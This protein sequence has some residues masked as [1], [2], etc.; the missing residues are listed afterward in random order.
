MAHADATVH[1]GTIGEAVECKTCYRVEVQLY[2]CLLYLRII[3]FKNLLMACFESQ[4]GNY[5]NIMFIIFLHVNDSVM[6][7]N[8]LRSLASTNFTFRWLP[9]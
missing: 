7:Y 8:C 9:V 5:S 2:H 6:P 3:V 4:F 1:V